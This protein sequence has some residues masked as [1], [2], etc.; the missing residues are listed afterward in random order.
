[1]RQFIMVHKPDENDLDL[2]KET[3]KDLFTEKAPLNLKKDLH[4]SIADIY[5]PAP[6]LEKLNRSSI[7]DQ[8][9]KLLCD[10]FWGIGGRIYEIHTSPFENMHAIA[11]APEEHI[12]ETDEHGDI[13]ESE[14]TRGIARKQSIRYLVVS[15]LLFHQDEILLQERSPQ[16]ELDQGLLSASAHGVAKALYF[17]DGKRMVS[18][19]Y[20]SLINSALEINEELRHGKDTQPFI[21]K[22][23]YGSVAHLK[24]FAAEEHINNPNT[25]YL[26]PSGIFEDDS[27]PLGQGNNKRTRAIS[28]G[29]LFSKDK[30]SLSIDPAELTSV[31]WK[32]PS[33]FVNNKQVTE[34]LQACIE[35][36]FDIL[37]EEAK[38]DG[39]LKMHESR[40]LLS[41]L[42]GS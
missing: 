35:A 38:K 36:A 31:N 7:A 9:G 21:I 18:T 39:S 42:L 20:V 30:P 17:S 3:T 4:Q 40:K 16:K 5:G 27:Y 1:M 33:I 14:I 23:W 10:I 34:D 32:K 11:E 12:C 24:K 8:D 22:I 6:S 19:E 28:L 41:E 25:V 15:T 29:F 37:L 26:V 2:K 13:I